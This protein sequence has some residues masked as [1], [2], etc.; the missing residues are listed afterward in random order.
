VAGTLELNQTN[1]GGIMKPTFAS[2]AAVAVLVVWASG[3]AAAGPGNGVGSR[4]LGPEGRLLRGGGRIAD[5]LK[6]T[7]SQREKLREIRDDL[8]RQ[9]IRT[10]ADLSLARLDLARS[11]RSETPDRSEIEG[12]ID[13]ISALRA[14]LM[15]TTTMARLDA[16]KILTVEQKRQLR[17]TR[18]RDDPRLEKG[19]G[20]QRGPRRGK[21]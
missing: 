17:E 13:A 3:G 15:K 8:A 4:I 7:T 2:L 9:V 14:S 5:E 20:L 19:R 6:L 10:R 16:N 18:F 11:L 1:W 21:A 12:R